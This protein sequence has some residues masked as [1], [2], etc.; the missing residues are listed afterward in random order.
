MPETDLIAL[1]VP[2]KLVR[3]VQ[4][5]ARELA[6]QAREIEYTAGFAKWTGDKKS[7]QA[8]LRVPLG[9][10]AFGHRAT[11]RSVK[12]GKLQVSQS[13]RGGSG[14]VRLPVGVLLFHCSPSGAWAVS[15]SGLGLRVSSSASWMLSRSDKWPS[16]G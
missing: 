4:E 9:R 7:N 2:L 15:L 10:R 5:R 12:V 1:H 16:L 6:A 8:L 3:G 14:Y 11:P 13:F